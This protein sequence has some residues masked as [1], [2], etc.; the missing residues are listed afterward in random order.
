[1]RES[2]IA[3][4]ESRPGRGL[5]A[6]LLLATQL[7][8]SGCIYWWKAEVE[9]S[10]RQ[11]AQTP[12]AA[13]SVKAPPRGTGE[14]D[15]A[16]ALS[17]AIREAGSFPASS[18]SAQAGAGRRLD[19]AVVAG[20]PGTQDAWFTVD[21][22]FLFIVP[23]PMAYRYDVLFALTTPGSGTRTYRYALA[24]KGLIWLP[25]LPFWWISALTPSAEDA[26]RTIVRRFIADSTGDKVW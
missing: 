19:V 3:F 4:I 26:A 23:L 18:E 22:I 13:L 1:L 12:Q 17:K 10:R 15:L 25:L 9:P 14:P 6:G 24:E 21:A 16:A 2:R 7:A 8:S 5:L 20:P 11:P